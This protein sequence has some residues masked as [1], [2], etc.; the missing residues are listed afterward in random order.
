MKTGKTLQELAAELERQSSARRDFIAPQGKV[1]AIIATNNELQISG[2]NGG[3]MGLTRLAHKQLADVLGIPTRYWDRMRDEQP[4]LLAGNINTWLRADP[5]NRRMLRTLDG[6]VRAVL[7]PKYRAL[8]NFE[9]AN[10]VLPKLLELEAEV[11]SSELTETR[12]YVKAILPTLSDELPR[13][14]AWGNGH[15]QVAEYSGNE[16]GKVVAAIVLSNSEVGAGSLR[17]EPSVF[18][19]WCTNL[20]IMKETAMRKYHVGRATRSGEDLEIFRDETRQADDRAFFMKVADVTTAAFDREVFAAAVQRIRDAAEVK[21]ESKDI[22]AV[23]DVTVK[24]M[25]LPQSSGSSILSFLARGGD[26]SKWGLSSAITAAGSELDSYEQATSFER[27]GGEVITLGP[28][29]WSEIST[30]K[31]A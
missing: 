1:E 8:D 10:A 14:L 11:V 30:A 2:L 19:T 15:H 18:T 3:P 25:A 27:A 22:A 28:R 17:V 12:M 6:W 7:S 23:V 20:A 31:A 29:D 26:M 5:H 9:L 21:I 13:G 24:K 16:T 4:G